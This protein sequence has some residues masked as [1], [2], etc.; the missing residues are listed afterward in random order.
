[1]L[2]VQIFWMCVQLLLYVVYPVHILAGE[3][4]FGR[5]VGLQGVF[6]H[7]LSS[8]HEGEQDRNQDGHIRVEAV[9]QNYDSRFFLRCGAYYR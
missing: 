5:L 9:S 3:D 7:L 2:K 6:S 4:N 8:T 1:M